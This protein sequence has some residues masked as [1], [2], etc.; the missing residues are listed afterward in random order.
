MEI[1]HGVTP[2]S[3]ITSVMMLGF[4]ERRSHRMVLAAID[5]GHLIVA[6]KRL[7]IP[8]GPPEE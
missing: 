2:A 8:K 4:N 5:G 7:P 6:E 3:I 1:D